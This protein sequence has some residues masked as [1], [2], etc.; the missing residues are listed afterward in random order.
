LGCKISDA[1][2]YSDKTGEI[3]AEMSQAKSNSSNVNSFKTVKDYGAKGDGKTDDTK[4]IQAAID[5]RNEVIFERG[6]YLI[7]SPLIFKERILIS[8]KKA[9]ITYTGNDAAIKAEKLV[10]DVTINNL[11]IETSADGAKAI[12]FSNFSYSHLSDIYLII[13]GKNSVGLYLQGNGE[14][15]APYYN[16]FSDLYIVGANKPSIT[17]QRGIVLDE[18]KNSKFSAS[19][20]NGNF[21]NNIKRI[22]GLSIAVDLIS[23]NGNMF[24][25]VGTESIQDYHFRFNNRSADFTGKI[26][27]ID[28]NSLTDTKQDFGIG[29]L[30]K[31]DVV[32][33]EGRKTK[34]YTSK[35]IA[36]RKNKLTTEK[37][38]NLATADDAQYEVYKSKAQG[39]IFNNIRVE[40]SNNSVLA[41]FCY[42]AAD[43]RL[44]N[45][46]VSSIGRIHVIRE[47]EDLSNRV[48]QPFPIV[49]QASDLKPNS[50]L[51]LTPTNSYLGGVPI[52]TTSY[53]DA[54]QIKNTSK[55]NPGTC[56][57][58]LFRSSAE[59]PLSVELTP[60]DG[61]TATAVMTEYI[62][63]G[64][65][66][67][68]PNDGLQL[69]ITTDENWKSDNI[70]VTVWVTNI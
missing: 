21:F 43:N 68:R 67:L 14:G 69:K 7:K 54:V 35:I 59:I 58:S 28:N 48:G 39:N 13:R 65:G 49:F 12:D 56:K 53:V 47:T 64:F 15:S 38:R 46:I 11:G 17:N 55:N 29:M 5:S 36:F 70:I 50:S 22:A 61:N 51:Q 60:A 30:S 63:T 6:T 18:K 37:H 66:L 8:G 19:G 3:N 26:S 45:I 9:Q 32:I 62:P 31:A 27:S 20:A 57:V 1:N 25:G 24:T 40:G 2:L 16:S 34:K 4:A 42:G 33:K 52:P 10:L 41:K 23:G 44:D